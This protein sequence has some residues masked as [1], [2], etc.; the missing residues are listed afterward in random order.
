MGS[1]Q[2]SLDQYL[3]SL[4]RHRTG[5][6][7]TS[8]AAARA[9]GFRAS[10][11]RLIALRTLAAHADGLTDFELA[12]LTGIAQTSIG[13]R[14]GECAAAGLVEAVMISKE[15]VDDDD[16]FGVKTA[17]ETVTLKRPAPSGSAAIVWRIT[18]AGLDYLQS[19]N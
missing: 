7:H 11:G 17:Q 8:I 19:M 4:P 2:L 1:A 6:Q 3:Q 12:D 18:Q 15:S 16:E 14:R 10:E 13:K 9:A 5:D